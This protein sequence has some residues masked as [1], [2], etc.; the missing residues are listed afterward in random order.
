MVNRT[1]NDGVVAV[2]EQLVR[3]WDEKACAQEVSAM[4]WLLL[5]AT[6]AAEFC[7]RSPQKVRYYQYRKSTFQDV[8]RTICRFKDL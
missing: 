2:A 6:A 8:I 5:N 1:V 4:L 7:S 3:A